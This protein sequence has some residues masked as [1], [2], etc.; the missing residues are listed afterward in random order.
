MLMG[1][2]RTDVHNKRTSDST[3]LAEFLLFNGWAVKPH[4]RNFSEYITASTGRKR[5][6]K[7]QECVSKYTISRYF[8][9]NICQKNLMHWLIIKWSVTFLFIIVVMNQ[10][11]CIQ[12]SSFIRWQKL[13]LAH[14]NKIKLSK[15]DIAIKCWGNPQTHI[16][17]SSKRAYS[18]IFSILSTDLYSFKFSSQII[19]LCSMRDKFGARWA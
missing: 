7:H 9:K 10:I 14:K 4:L 18:N 17:Y 11:I 3:F 16:L 15:V 12:I 2:I 5:W 13:P 1:M 19:F 8:S 6:G